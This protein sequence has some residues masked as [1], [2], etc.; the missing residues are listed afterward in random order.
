MPANTPVSEPIVPTA[1]ALLLHVPPG[2]A[3]VSVVVSPI[4]TLVP[5]A[6]A[7]GDGI[8]VTVRKAVQPE[9]SE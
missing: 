7:A 8:T 1:G 6:I 3:S 9:P 5:P 2:V 4:H